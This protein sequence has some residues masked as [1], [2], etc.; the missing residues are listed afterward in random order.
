MEVCAILLIISH[1]FLF[2][3]WTMNYSED[4]VKNISIDFNSMTIYSQLLVYYIAEHSCLIIVFIAAAK[5][6]L[7]DI[8]DYYRFEFFKLNDDTFLVQALDQYTIPENEDNFT[9][10]YCQLLYIYLDQ[11]ITRKTLK[12]CV[13]DQWFLSLLTQFVCGDTDVNVLCHK[14]LLQLLNESVMQNSSNVVNNEE[15]DEND[16]LIVVRMQDNDHPDDLNI[17]SL[18]N[19]GESANNEPGHDK[20]NSLSDF[21]MYFTP[22][23]YKY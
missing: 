2:W 15:N 10:T 7:D 22:S 12:L 20:I 23:V 18:D 17:I 3:F 4:Q 21:G 8:S 19:K 1:L 6:Y 14:E 5:I 13:K 16:D 11:F 9:D